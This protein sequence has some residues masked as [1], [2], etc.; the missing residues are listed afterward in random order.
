MGLGRELSDWMRGFFAEG[1]SDWIVDCEDGFDW[2]PSNRRQSV[3]FT[4]LSPTSDGEDRCRI[5]ISTDVVRDVEAS[6]EMDDELNWMAKECTLSGLVFTPEESRIRISANMLVSTE[7]CPGISGLFGFA[8]MLQFKEAM[9]AS[10]RLVGSVGATDDRSDHPTNGF[11][12]NP[13]PIESAVEDAVLPLGRPLPNDHETFETYFKEIDGHLEDLGCCLL[14]NI[15]PEGV[16]TE[17]PWG[18][19]E[20]SLTKLWPSQHPLV[21]KGVQVE[22]HFPIEFPNSEFYLKNARALNFDEL[23][24]IPKGQG[25]GAFFFKPDTRMIV[26]SSF[27]PM[28]AI[29]GPTVGSFVRERNALIVQ[30]LVDRARLMSEL[31]TGEK[32]TAESFDPA[33]T[34]SGR[35]FAMFDGDEEAYIDFMFKMMSEK[36]ENEGKDN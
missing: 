34:A 24:R 7:T 2:W 31:F 1:E 14:R 3:R 5:S 29:S 20:S 16:T 8:A 9:L 11:R 4:E 35:M 6:K 22:Q 30:S 19:D 28:G 10:K 26:W 32:W 27:I 12:E 21:G 25:F 33:R 17:F 36:I 15:G 23:T 13:N 18:K